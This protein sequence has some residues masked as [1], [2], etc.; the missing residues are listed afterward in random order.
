M[1]IQRFRSSNR[2]IPLFGKRAR[3]S[4]RVRK[5]RRRLLNASR[6]LRVSSRIFPIGEQG[7]MTTMMMMRSTH[8]RGWMMIERISFSRAMRFFSPLSPLSLSRSLKIAFG[9][10]SFIFFLVFLKFFF[11]MRARSI[12]RFCPSLLP[13]QVV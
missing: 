13:S 1:D 8:G 10:W 7:L 2:G 12:A 4:A 11:I 9:I 5:Y 3:F 6:E